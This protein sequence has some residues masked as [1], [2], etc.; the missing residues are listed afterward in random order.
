MT[1]TAP[2]P[3][4]RRAAR[5]RA[6]QQMLKAERW[7]GRQVALAI[8]TSPT[9]IQA[10]FHGKV[11]LSFTDIEQIAPLLRMTSAELFVALADA[12]HGPETGAASLSVQDRRFNNVTHIMHGRVS[13]A[14]ERGETATVTPIRRAVGA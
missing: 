4:D 9:N 10:R 6:L 3:D 13:E 12:E 14:P 1:N 5:G 11:D 2:I 7:T 8:G